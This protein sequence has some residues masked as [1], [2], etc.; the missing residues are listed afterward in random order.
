M[1][2]AAARG[3][4]RSV[5]TTASDSATAGRQVSRLRGRKIGWET[6]EYRNV[7]TTGTAIQISTSATGHPIS[8]SS[9]LPRPRVRRR[10]RTTA[11]ASPSSTST[12]AIRPTVVV[13][14][15]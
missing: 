7:S 15:G 11:V 14:R 10:A 12:V 1:A 9:P 2:G 6:S 8:G 4:R 13:K 3:S 5:I